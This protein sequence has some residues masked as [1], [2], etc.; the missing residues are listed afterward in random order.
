MKGIIRGYT[1]VD[2]PYEEPESPDLI[3]DTEKVDVEGA[4]SI[5]IE[6]LKLKGWI[7]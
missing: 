6:T 2:A 3:I 5:L 7:K 1:G 4:I